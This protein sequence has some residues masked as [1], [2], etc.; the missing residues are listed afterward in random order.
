[1]T[2]L[3]VVGFSNNVIN[4]YLACFNEAIKIEKIDSYS[5]LELESQKF[6]ANGYMGE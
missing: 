5:I 1:M 2:H 4:K 6:Y 3:V